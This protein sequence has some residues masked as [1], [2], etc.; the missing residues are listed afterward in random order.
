MMTS[1]LL[2]LTLTSLKIETPQFQAPVKLA[3]IDLPSVPKVEGELKAAGKEAEITARE[4]PESSTIKLAPA[5]LEEAQ[6]G[7]GFVATGRGLKATEPIDSLS[8]PKLPAQAPAFKACVRVASPDR[9]P[10]RVKA[11]IKLPNGTELASVSRTVWFDG[12]W[13]DV[14]FDFA[15]LQLHVPGTYKVV[16]S[17]DGS[18]VAELPLEVRSLKQAAEPSGR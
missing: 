17:L 9:T 7:R 10:T 1:L 11:Q 8:L 2:A 14:V 5:R 12:E 4:A 3:P 18:V 6:V 13:A 15:T 16:F